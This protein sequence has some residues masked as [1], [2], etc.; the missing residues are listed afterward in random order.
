MEE[1]DIV[2][3]QDIFDNIADLTPEQIYFFIKQKKFTTFDR[4]KD[5]RNTHSNCLSW[6]QVWFPI[7]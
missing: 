1:L 3:E 5:P 7:R 4:L 6:S 2:E